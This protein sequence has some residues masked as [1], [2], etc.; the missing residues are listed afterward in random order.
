M[1]R[2][3]KLGRN[4]LCWCK[5]GKKYKSCHLS[6]D[7]KLAVLAS[8]NKLIPDHDMIKN[9]EQI[10]GIREA[11]RLNTEILDMISE[12]VQEGISTGEINR[13]VHEYTIAHGGIPAPLNYEGFPKSVC[14]S[15]DD[16]VCH[17][18]PDDGRVLRSGEII[19]IDVT[20]ILGGY[21]G[22]ASRMYCIGEVSEE[23]KRLVQVAKE[24]LD[25]GLEAV[26]PWGHL[27][28]VGY[29]V[30][31]HAVKNGYTVVREIGG[32][33][34]GVDF[35]EEPWVS[36]IGQPGTD[37]VLAPGM[38]FTIEPMVNMGAADVWQDEEDGWTIRTEDGEPSAQWEYTI[39]VTETGTEILSR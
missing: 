30:N 37:I 17:G 8:Q 13:L 36:H 23:K 32:H 39:L 15:I 9:Q 26:K 4:D 11:G 27:G 22:D 28:D 21:Y 33:G 20:T 7:E 18:I 5:S 1:E 10:A 16:V 12:H 24:C 38:I 25:L 3:M 31:T 19:N 14:T 34:V 35:H 2:T 6:F 29:A